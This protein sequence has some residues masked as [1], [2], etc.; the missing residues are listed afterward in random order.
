LGKRQLLECDANEH[1]EKTLEFRTVIIH[2]YEA[3]VSLVENSD[4]P[5]S[6]KLLE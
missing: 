2:A 4:N 5:L 1:L 3:F 6:A